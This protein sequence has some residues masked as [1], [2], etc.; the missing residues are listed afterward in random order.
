M[1]DWNTQELQLSQN[2]QYMQV[3]AMCGH[4]KPNN[5]MSSMLLINFEEEKPKP[6]WEAY[7]L[8]P[9]LDWEEKNNVKGKGTETEE[10][11]WEMD[12]LIWI[13]NNK[14][15]LTPSWEWEKSNKGKGKAKKEEPLPKNTYT[16]Y[17]HTTP[18]QFT[19]R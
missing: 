7:Q 4:F 11:T 6:T 5:I 8:L 17:Q 10:H 19:Y 14:R 13:N 12:D 3:P 1:F 9:I 15:E 2:G 18:Q 16:S